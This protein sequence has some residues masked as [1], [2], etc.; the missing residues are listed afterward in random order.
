MYARSH[1]RNPFKILQYLEGAIDRF[2]G[3]RGADLNGSLE[4]SV[5]TLPWLRNARITRFD[6]APGAMRDAILASS[7]ATPYT[8]VWL[9]ALRS[10]CIDGAVSD[11]KLVRGVLLGRRFFSLHQVREGVGWWRAGRARRARRVAH[12]PSSLL[13]P[14]ARRLPS[15]PGRRVRGRVRRLAV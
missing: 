9:P 15:R 1:W 12:P 7:C 2:V 6:G 13:H 11:L 4:V 5:T 3:A 14:S 10:W 8:P